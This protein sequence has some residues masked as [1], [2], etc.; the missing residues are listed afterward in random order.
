MAMKVLITGANGMVAR[1]VTNY[2]QTLGDDGRALTHADLD[3]S[4]AAEVERQIGAMRPDA[5]LNCAAFTDVDGAETNVSQCFAVNSTGVENLA[6]ACRENGSV[7]VTISTD[8]VFDGEKAGF[9][10][11]DD[12]PNPQS[13]YAKSKYEGELRAADANPDSIIVR[14]G[15]IFGHHGTNFLS[16][17]PA[18]LKK[19]QQI[20]VISDSFGTPTYADDLAKS[21]RQLAAKRTP[22]IYHIANAG[23]GTSYHGYAELVCRITELNPRFLDIVSKDSLRRPAPRPVNS[24]LAAADSQPPLPSWRNALERFLATELEKFGIW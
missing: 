2:C 11:P 13:I 1:A 8:Y 17:I 16:V 5:V 7:F 4:N 9:Y 15:W 23:P 21:L 14:S 10:Y 6:K 24:R 12:Q 18:L 20:K 19:R 3:I 22:G